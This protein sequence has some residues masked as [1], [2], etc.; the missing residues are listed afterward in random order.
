MGSDQ[1]LLELSGESA[2]P[3]MRVYQ[4][5]PWCISLGYHQAADSLDM[6]ACAADGID[7]VRRPTGGRAVYH[8]REVTYAVVIPKESAFYRENLTE[9]YTLI[10][11]GLA[12]GIRLLGV[13]A[14]LQKRH[15]DLNTHYK[16]SMSVSCFSAAARNE[17]LVAGKK[18]IGS[19]QRHLSWGM[20]QHGSI[21]SGQAHLDLSRYLAGNSPHDQE[22]LRSII[23]KKTITLGQCLEQEPAVETVAAALRKGMETLLGITFTDSAMTAA[24][25]ARARELRERF[26]LLDTAQQ[27][28]VSA[29]N[30]SRS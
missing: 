12:G 8:A 14:E 29:A 28:A 3:V 25:S 1:A 27:T 30:G 17:V 23:A 6:A 18:L 11:E 10:S 21:L 22:R 5:D 24:E 4:W 16:K 26:S 7:V 20:L 13:S 19:A 15:V 9:L 2:R